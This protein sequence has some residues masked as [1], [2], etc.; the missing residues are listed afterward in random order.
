MAIVYP[1]DTII[2]DRGDGE[3]KYIPFDPSLCAPLICTVIA[4]MLIV[5]KWKGVLTPCILP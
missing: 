2:E 5:E 4:L 1:S 3:Y